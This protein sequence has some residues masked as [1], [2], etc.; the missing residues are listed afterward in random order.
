MNFLKR[1]F[2]TAHKTDIGVTLTLPRQNL[3]GLALNSKSSVIRSKEVPKTIFDKSLQTLI[4]V[5]FGEY[6]TINSLAMPLVCHTFSAMTGFKAPFLWKRM[7][8]NPPRNRDA[9]V[10]CI[11]VVWLLSLPVS[12][13]VK[14]LS[15]V[16]QLVN[17]KSN[18]IEIWWEREFFG[19]TGDSK[20]VNSC[21][22]S[23]I[24]Y[25]MEES[26]RGF[27]DFHRK[28]KSDMKKIIKTGCYLT[29]W[30]KRIQFV[31]TTCPNCFKLVN[32]S[33]QCNYCK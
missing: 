21:R 7:L 25:L 10:A 15:Y 24:S 1:K 27:D 29:M 16:R 22:D 13:Q 3:I 4:D 17:F 28:S 5:E 8:S 9:S 12:T 30:G 18:N 19:F 32:A 26:H 31:R 23:L 11:S 33:Q 6:I 14:L 20:D 2:A